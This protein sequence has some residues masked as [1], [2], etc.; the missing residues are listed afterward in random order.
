MMI[1]MPCFPYQYCCNYVHVP[2]VYTET[3]LILIGGGY[4]AGIGTEKR[5]IDSQ[6]N[7][8]SLK[9]DETLLA[10]SDKIGK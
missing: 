8:R 7:A 1:N 5:R 2:S 6:E 10:A 4:D 3:W 9:N